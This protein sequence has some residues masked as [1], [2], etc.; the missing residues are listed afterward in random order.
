MPA[1]RTGAV[2]PA[3]SDQKSGRPMRQHADW[4]ES[5]A[6]PSTADGFYGDPIDPEIRPL[7][8]A[9][10]DDEA[11]DTLG[12]CCGHGRAHATVDLALRGVD[13]TRLFV[14]RLNRVDAELGGSVF[15]DVALNWSASVATA[16]DFASF[17]D[18]IMV[19]L[20]ISEGGLPPSADTLRR[21]AD[22]Y[23]A[24]KG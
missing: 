4:Q 10:R 5:R 1:S 16:C 8:V 12:S 6:R 20:T 15:L 19:A 24:T 7:V 2:S 22:L 17:P 14:E 9:L 18:W 21:V 13:G 11:V 23:S 3:K